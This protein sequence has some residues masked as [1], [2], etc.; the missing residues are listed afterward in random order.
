MHN[1]L[2]FQN[3]GF[4]HSYIKNIFFQKAKTNDHTLLSTILLCGTEKIR[5]ASE[6]YL[7]A[8][9]KLSTKFD[10]SKGFFQDSQENFL[11]KSLINSETFI[12]TPDY[13]I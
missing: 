2:I 7:S 3:E 9:L 8:S 4:L 13:R 5:N 10:E 6:I 12:F 11:R 1:N